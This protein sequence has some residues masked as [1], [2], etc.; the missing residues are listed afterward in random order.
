MDTGF[1]KSLGNC[2][3]RRIGRCD[4]NEI[5]AVGPH[6]F[7]RQHFLPVAIGAVFRNPKTLGKIASANRVGIKRARDHIIV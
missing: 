1:E 2:V 7:A 3:M 5:N 6:P 4:R